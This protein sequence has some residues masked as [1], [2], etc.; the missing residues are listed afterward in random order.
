MHQEAVKTMSERDTTRAW[1]VSPVGVLVALTLLVV[2]VALTTTL[3]RVRISEIPPELCRIRIRELVKL[4]LVYAHE[5]GG[6]LPIG[7]GVSPRAHDSLNVL[8]RFL[9]LRGKVSPENFVCP[10]WDGDVAV[11]RTDGTFVLTDRTCGFAWIDHLA[12]VSDG[13]FPIMSE[14]HR[15]RGG[16]GLLVGLSDGSVELF[17]E[18]QLGANGLPAGLTR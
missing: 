12:N 9:N 3:I 15:C 17:T 7:E 6:F 16:E 1:I 4:A 14:K 2:V 11:R 18:A 13:R 5:N 10:C 8:A